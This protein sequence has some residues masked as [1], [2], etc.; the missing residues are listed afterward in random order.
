MSKPDLGPEKDLKPFIEEVAQGQALPPDAAEEVF[1]AV[2]S[3]AA[4]PVQVGAILMGL[5]TR[6]VLPGE[7]AGGVRALQ[8][9]MIAV[10]ASD[11]E[12]LTDTCGTGGGSLTTFN[13]ST[14]AA[15]VAAGL[16]VRVAKHG[17]RSFTSK[18]GSAD[19]LEALGV[20][21]QLSPESMGRVL[22]ET[23][24]VFMFAP[25]LHPAMRNVAPVRQELGITTIMNLLGPLTN[26][27]GALRQM[28]GVAE[29]G[30]LWLI[31]EALRELGHK[32]ALVVHG[33][34]GMDEMSPLGP[35]QVAE[36]REDGAI[37]EGMITP[38]QLG[39]GTYHPESLKGG[40]PEENAAVI[41]AVLGGGGESGARAAVLLN[42]AGALYVSGKGESLPEALEMAGEGL[43]AGVGLE[44]LGELREAS[45]SV[46]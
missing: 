34:P 36:L 13:I 35:T 17:N 1:S 10:P 41:T 7:V 31:V 2:I 23:G 6:G 14:A 3:G 12:R 29:P 32:R 24:I 26:P 25:L 4:S 28:V 42:A 43:D 20:K 40:T 44:K 37:V 19:V 11:P 33:S 45:N 15:L 46:D 39:L 27:A 5:R 38:G 18:S 16:G 9:A 30:I 21:I 8:K 22:A